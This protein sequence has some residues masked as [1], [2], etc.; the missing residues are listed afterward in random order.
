MDTLRAH[1]YLHLLSGQPASTLLDPAPRTSLP[2]AAPPRPD[3]PATPPPPAPARP[4]R[5]RELD[6]APVGVAG[7]DPVPRRGPGFGPLDAADSRTLA[8]LLAASPASQWCVTLTDRAGH[9]VA[10]ACAPPAPGHDQTPP[11]PGPGPASPGRSRTP[12]RSRR[13]G[14]RTRAG[15]VTGTSTGTRDG[16]Q[17]PD[18]RPRQTPRHRAAGLAPHPHLHHPAN[19]RLHPPPRITRLPAQPR[20][21]PP[22]RNPQPH[23]HRPRLPPRR[24]PLR[25][26][27]RHPLPPRR[28]NLR[29]QPGTRMPPRPPDQ[30]NPRL[31]PHHPRPGTL[32]WTTPGNRTH[33]TTPAHY[34]E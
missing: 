31:D 26:R 21:A 4:A 29:M 15:P 32:T 22:D 1:A 6:H 18:P 25:P 33:T 17:A 23:L 12:S 14:R 20:P 13:P 11:P 2:G 5:R 19:P 16:P 27:P 10:H 28:T 7:L 34:P 30:A 24:H 9:P 8:G 3:Y